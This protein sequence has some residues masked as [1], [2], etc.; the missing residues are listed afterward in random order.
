MVGIHRV[1]MQLDRCIVLGA[2]D[3]AIMIAIGA[4][5]HHHRAH[6]THTTHAR[7]AV[8]ATWTHVARRSRGRTIGAMV[9]SRSMAV[10]HLV[11]HR[12]AIGLVDHAVVVGIDPGET[13]IGVRLEFGPVHRAVAVDAS[14]Q[15]HTAT[16]GS[17]L[18]HCTNRANQS[19]RCSRQGQCQFLHVAKTPV[20]PPDAEGER[21]T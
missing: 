2:G 7:A 15:A 17:V 13:F 11:A 8:S 14:G 1:K 16:V 20:G 3:L 9:G 5:Q 10:A 21:Q 19:K 6:A 12:F 4:T 18:R